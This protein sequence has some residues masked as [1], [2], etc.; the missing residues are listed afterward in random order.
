MEILPTLPI[1]FGF[2]MAFVILW[3][4]VLGFVNGYN[5]AIWVLIMITGVGGLTILGLL[6]EESG[7]W[8]YHEPRRTHTVTHTR[9]VH[10]ERP[11]NFK[12]RFEDDFD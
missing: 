10:I 2:A 1:T 6:M 11:S 3:G 7:D 8:D 12:R 4:A 9:I 5:A